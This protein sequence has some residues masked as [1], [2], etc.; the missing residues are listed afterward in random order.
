MRDI[1]VVIHGG[2][3]V[4][5][6]PVFIDAFRRYMESFEEGIRVEV[7]RNGESSTC[8]DISDF[9]AVGLVRRM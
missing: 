9:M 1:Y 5:V 3:N 2:V 8:C 7:W 6:T 4:L